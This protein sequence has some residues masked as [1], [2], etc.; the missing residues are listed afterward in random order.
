MAKDIPSTGYRGIY[1]A[2]ATGKDP[3]N[4][5]AAQTSAADHFAAAEKSASGAVA[6]N[7]DRTTSG[8]AD[9]A[10]NGFTPRYT[11]AGEPAQKSLASRNSQGARTPLGAANASPIH[12]ASFGKGHFARA[13]KST[14]SGGKNRKPLFAIG[15]LTGL[16]ALIMFATSS[17]LPIHLVE[18]MIGMK[19]SFGTTAEVRGTRLIQRVLG[20]DNTKALNTFSKRNTLSAKRITQMNRGLEA[21]GLRLRADGDNV[22]LQSA[23]G[24]DGKINFEAD[25]TMRWNTAAVSEVEFAALI[26]EHPNIR[27]GFNKGAQGITG[28]TSG[29]YNRAMAFFLNKNA[30]TRN[31][32]KDFIAKTEGNTSYHEAQELIATAEKKV[33]KNNID[34]ATQER[35]TDPE[36]GK[37]TDSLSQNEIGQDFPAAKAA[38]GADIRARALQIAGRAGGIS[39]ALTASCAVFLAVGAASAV[40]AA[41]EMAKGLQVVA[42][43]L[44]AGQ[45]M[46]AGEGDESYYALGDALTIQTT[47]TAF[48]KDG[49]EIELHNGAQKSA[50]ESAGLQNVLVGGTFTAENDQSALKYHA[51]KAVGYMGITGGSVAGCLAAMLAGGVIGAVAEAFSIVVSFVPIAGQAFAI[52]KLLAKVAAD[53]ATQAA[54]SVAIGAGVGALTA[55][56]AKGL[57]TTIA[58]DVEGEDFGNLLASVGGRY[59]SGVHQANGGV[60]ATEERALAYYRE[61]QAVLARQAESDRAERSPFDITT[62]NTFLGSLAYNMSGFAA[63]SSLFSNLTGLASAVQAS[64]LPLQ[65]RASADVAGE[66]AFKDG[67]GNCPQLSQLYPE[68]ITEGEDGTVHTVACDLFGNPIRTND[69]EAMEL[70]PEYVFWKTA[71]TCDGSECSFGKSGDETQTYSGTHFDGTEWTLTGNATVEVDE[72]GLE[73]INPKSELGKMIVY[74]VNRSTDPG[75]LDLNIMMA[76]DDSGPSWLGWAPVVGEIQ[77]AVSAVNQSEALA[78]GWVDGKNYCNGCTEEWDT[79]YRYLNQYIVDDNLYEVMGGVEKSATVAFLEEEVWPTMD[80]SAEG[81][82]ARNMGVSKDYVSSSLAYVSDLLQTPQSEEALVASAPSIYATYYNNRQIGQLMLPKKDATYVMLA[83]IQEPAKLPDLRRRF[84]AEVMA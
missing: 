77:Q 84:N 40:F 20:K 51:E 66:L 49:N 31:L 47:T 12:P 50:T 26:A 76:E 18:N 60:V 56:L 70:D 28:R 53:T 82:L 64:S 75:V 27:N 35:T 32:F 61:T 21:E 39:T 68:G 19:N 11:G 67:L 83:K 30:L 62:K 7:N 45:K 13:R 44:E 41:M 34:L 43:W 54:I 52:G 33:T 8:S 57:I 46:Q 23:L 78:S 59:M 65:W 4:I 69:L 2:E 14:G 5:R 15:G 10:E 72:N 3:A 55:M 25:G 17:L 42:A 58:T 29:W 6:K 71:F 36:T 81:I 38:I 79:K 37:T 74:G 9:M 16:L 1:G 22:I 48:D 63:S 73:K 80:Q 24:A